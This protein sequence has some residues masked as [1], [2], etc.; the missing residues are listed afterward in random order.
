[1]RKFIARVLKAQAEKYI[2]KYNLR[3][4]V[5]AGSV[6]KTSTTYAIANILSEQFSVRSTI[7]NY[8]T[9][10]GVPCSIF[11][12]P[13]PNSLRN[14]FAWIWIFV[15]NFV[16]TYKKPPFEILVLEIGTDVPGEIEQFKW[17]KPDIAVVTAVADEH[18]EFFKSIDAVAK[19]ELSV[20][21]YSA[22]TIINKR[23][24]ANEY[25]RYADSSE[26]YNYDREDIYH[27]GL[28][29]ADLQVA[30]EHSIDAVAA[31]IAVG[32]TLGMDKESLARGA[33]AV[34]PLPGR[35]QP[36]RGIKNSTIIDDTYN[37]SPESV[38]AALDY[39][40]ASGAPQKIVLLGNMNELGET[41]AAS[42]MK[43]GEYCNSSKIDLVLTLGPDANKHTAPK[44]KQKGCMVIETENPY[45]A[46]EII[47]DNMKENAL[48]LCKGSQN[49]VFAEETVK[50]LLANPD[51]ASKLVR[52]SK[53][54][55]KI[56]AD[57]FKEIT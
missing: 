41:S 44:A 50:L 36:L 14:P 9:D 2:N 19:E 10:I 57:C 1:M 22:K 25:L 28:V 51:D 7:K 46:A 40:Y 26:L 20:S 37:A 23:M 54:W 53:F 49:K 31:G 24:V 38:L 42:H 30:G 21:N 55:M 33:K 6:G 3:V 43:I 34:N 16:L 32:K 5:V 8:N 35:M 12:Q 48:I 27:I 52:Q 47:K 4:V 39:V 15:K 29:V 17:L 13:I 45:Q 56:K 11:N 18:M